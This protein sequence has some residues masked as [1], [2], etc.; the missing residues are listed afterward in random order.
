MP[1]MKMELVALFKNIIIFWPQGI[2]VWRNSPEKRSQNQ[3]IK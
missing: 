3:L 2:G 1:R